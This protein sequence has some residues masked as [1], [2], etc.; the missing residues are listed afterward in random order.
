MTSTLL[1]E[2]NWLPIGNA[3]IISQKLTYIAHIWALAFA[4]SRH[5]YVGVSLHA[6]PVPGESHIQR[7]INREVATKDTRITQKWLF[8]AQYKA[9][10]TL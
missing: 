5:I 10:V 7:H 9:D 1:K 2:A 8:I 3:I 6:H 4:C